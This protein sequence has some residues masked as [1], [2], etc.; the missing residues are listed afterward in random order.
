MHH[1]AIFDLPAH[2]FPIWGQAPFVRKLLMHLFS[3]EFSECWHL[4]AGKYLDSS[5]HEESR[6]IVDAELRLYFCSCY[7]FWM[8]DIRFFQ[9]P[10]HHPLGYAKV[11]ER[12]MSQFRHLGVTLFA[13]DRVGASTDALRAGMAAVLA[14][15]WIG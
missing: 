15:G 3:Y 9:K 5:F 7:H 10:S 6:L 11:P 8:P 12:R 13:A 1:L 4:F 14:N 2:V